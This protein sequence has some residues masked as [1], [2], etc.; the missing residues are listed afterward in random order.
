VEAIKVALVQFPGIHR[1]LP[2]ARVIRIF[3]KIAFINPETLPLKR[4]RYRYA[5]FSV[6]G[7]SARC[8]YLASGPEGHNYNFQRTAARPDV[9]TAPSGMV[10]VQVVRHTLLP[11]KTSAVALRA[12]NS[13]PAIIS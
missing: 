12:Q 4:A 2:L 13:E 6:D 8:P 7:C 9:G 10:W 11:Q 3:H 5:Q 1:A